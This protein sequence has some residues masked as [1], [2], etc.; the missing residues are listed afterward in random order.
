V[1]YEAAGEGVEIGGD[2]YDFVAVNDAQH[3]LIVGDVCGR[4]PSAASLNAQV[5]FSARALA[6]HGLR[7]RA[8]ADEI[9]RI[10][11]ADAEDDRFCTA[12]LATVEPGPPLRIEAVTAGHPGPVVLRANGE[13]ETLAATGPLLGVFGG[14]AYSSVEVVLEVG[15]TLIVLTDGLLEARAPSGDFFEP[16][17]LPLV[18]GLVGHDADNIASVIT[19]AVRRFVGGPLNDDLALVVIQPG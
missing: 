10:V 9:N 1:R 4:G 2:F 19:A 6:R 8:L 16:E 3:V 15:D 7:P 18:A 13:V 14:A 11:T 12:V 17:F 5:R